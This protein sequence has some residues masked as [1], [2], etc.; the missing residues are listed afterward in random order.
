MPAVARTVHRVLGEPG[1]Y[2]RFGFRAAHERG[3]GNE[4]HVRDEFMVMELAAGGL[5]TQPGVAR[6]AKEFSLVA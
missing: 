4:Y 1:Y 5:P 2:R 6:Y 3:I